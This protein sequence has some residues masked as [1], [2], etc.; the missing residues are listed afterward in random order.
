M[1]AE[2]HA[3]P[4]R[5]PG[6]F[7]P[8]GPSPVPEDVKALRDVPYATVGAKRLVLD[9]YLPTQAE[10]KMPLIVWIHG[11][12]WQSGSKDQWRP[13]ETFVRQGYAV[14]SIEYRLSGEAVFPA[15]IEDCKAA[16][17]WLKANAETYNLAADRIAVWGSSAGGHLAALVGT[18]GD[19]KDLEGT[20]GGNLDQSS[21]VQAVIDFFGP[22]DLEAFVVT[23]GYERHANAA[24]PESKLLGGAVR[25]VPHQAKRANP[26]TYVDSNDPPF[27]IVHGA[28]DPVVPPNQSELL[29]A[30]LEKAGV[31][32]ELTILPGNGHGGPGFS[33][34]EMTKRIAAFLERHLKPQSPRSA[35][36]GAG[37]TLQGTNWTYAQG[38]LRF[39]GVLLKPDGPGP[40]PAVLISHGLGGSAETF[41]MNKAREM[42]GWG[43]VCIAPNYTHSAK[44][45]GGMQP[46]MRPPPQ[47]GA[48]RPPPA[49]NYGA[50]DEN[51][52]RATTCLDILARLPN[53]D[54]QRITAY[55]H[56]MGGFVT[57]GLL[58]RE[59]ERIKAAAISGSGIAPRAGY[60]APSNDAAERIRTPMIMFHGALDTTV[61]P[62]QSAS[63]EKILDRNKV[64]TERHVYEGVNHPVDQQ[65]G[66]EMYALMKRWFAMYLEK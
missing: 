64:P 50:S 47:P 23:P 49:N 42:V 48:G 59:P 12:G 33:Q 66:R 11:G 39:D 36:E 7:R 8:G 54:K 55:G 41:G 1:V 16:L 63:L 24:S 46:G 30:A 56:S 58:A 3:Q 2:C 10:G 4:P 17:R 37:F 9:L 62:E 14:A 65:K 6:G 22:T 45:M 13:A 27:F 53:V 51:L 20:V 57:I 15:Q 43:Y 38:D 18:S 29:H 35:A 52:K 61:R 34:P 25:E 26:I 19:V 60:A 40:F 32:S 44:N 5:R 31:T 21:R 28:D